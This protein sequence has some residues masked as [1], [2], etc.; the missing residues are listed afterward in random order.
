[1]KDIL[2]VHISLELNLIVSSYFRE[3]RGAD[4]IPVIPPYQNYDHSH[5]FFTGAFFLIFAV[6]FRCRTIHKMIIYVIIGKI[7]EGVRTDGESAF[8]SRGLENQ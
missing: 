6:S 4:S 7:E 8:F 2:D 3:N 5:G 1:M